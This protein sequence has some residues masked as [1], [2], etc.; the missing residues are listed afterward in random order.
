MSNDPIP[1]PPG[2]LRDIVDTFRRH[3]FIVPPESAVDA[4]ITVLHGGRERR[5]STGLIQQRLIDCYRTLPVSDFL[6]GE[7]HAYAVS[8][9]L[10]TGKGIAGILT[11]AE[12]AAG[13]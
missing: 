4:M 2:L 8:L 12:Q 11:E 5:S 10:I 6:R 3:G 7:R 9:S 13:Q 1:L